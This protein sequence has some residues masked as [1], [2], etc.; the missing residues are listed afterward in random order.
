VWLVDLNP[1]RGHEQAGRRPAL[2]VSH[3]LFNRG[4][5][6][7]VLAV[8]I[9]S[10]RRSVA[11]HVPIDPPEAGMRQPSAILCEAIRSIARDRFHQR[12]GSVNPATIAAVEDRLRHLLN[13]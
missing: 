12:W 13:L 1:V 4:P 10:T 6:Q 11:Y 7:L 3:D 8:P 9:T 2:V 5:A